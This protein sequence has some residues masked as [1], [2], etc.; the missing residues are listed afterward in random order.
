M[1]LWP[2]VW[3]GYPIVFADTGTYLAQ[4]I[5]HF[6]GWDRPVFYSVFILPLHATVTLWPVIVVQAVLSA[7]ILWLVCRALLP[8][9]SRAAFVSGVAI[10]AVAT[11]LPWMVSEL[12]PDVF[13]P[14][15]V[16]VTCLLTWTPWCLSPRERVAL[17]GLAAFMIASQQSSLLLVCPLLAVL[18]LL[19]HRRGALSSGHDHDQSVPCTV[20]ALQR[21]RYDRHSHFC[22]SLVFATHCKFAR[23][24]STPWILMILPPALALIGLC[25]INFAAHG[26]FAVSPFGNIFLLARVIYDGPGMAV[27]RRDCPTTAWQLCPFLGTFP[28]SS[29]E[30]LWKQNSPLNQAGGPKVVSRDA[31]AIIRDALISDPA[32]EVRAALSNTLEQ[33]GRFASGDGLSP[34]PDQVTAEI[35]RDF[36]AREAASYASARQQVGALSVPPVLAH[37]HMAIAVIGV[38]ACLLLLPIALLRRTPCAGFLVAV[39]M[40]LP[41]SAAITGALSTPHDRY[42]SRIMWLPPFVAVISLASLRHCSSD[43]IGRGPQPQADPAT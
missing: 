14:L 17:I 28:P 5:H 2:A 32:G 34:W 16:L 22:D 4:A 37:L 24:R 9:V 40:A 6:A 18:G 27:L 3:N 23:W 29:D 10:L 7:W 43:P 20:L 15:L 8:R 25:S 11:W 39:L 31:D 42:Q 12:M 30:F 35:K 41:I 26:R 1:L 36:P 13:T 19:H 38:M 21:E 33:L